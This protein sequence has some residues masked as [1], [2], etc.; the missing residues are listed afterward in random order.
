MVG[1]MAGRTAVSIGKV[2]FHCLFI[3]IMAEGMGFEPTNGV[4][5]H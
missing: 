5:P 4:Y 2:L 3:E 1:K